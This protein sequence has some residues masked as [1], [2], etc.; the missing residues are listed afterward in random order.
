MPEPEIVI[1]DAL[2]EVLS[3]AEKV[4]VL[5]GA[6]VSADSGIPTFREA[7]TGLW[8]RFSPQELATPEAFHSNPK[9]VWEWYA[10]RRDL[11]SNSKPNAAHKALVDFEAFFPEFTLITQN[12]DGLHQMAG[13]KNVIE[14]H[15][16]I[17]KA[18]CIDEDRV[19][20]V[21]PVSNEYPLICPKCNGILRPEIVWFGESLP[22]IPLQK[23]FIASR[24]CAVFLSIGTS[25]IVE[26]AA[27]L[28]FEALNLGAVGIE[29]NLNQTGFSDYAHFS[30]RYKASDVLPII[31][32]IL[33]NH[34]SD[35]RSSSNRR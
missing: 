16:N 1:P 35:S 25:G 32:S 22:A 9:L 30:L 7:Q 5:T 6:G 14:L 15:G 28:P 17:T 11:I 3:K 21:W 2:I 26:P 10:W 24:N 34:H 33:K 23:A 29:V 27:S 19:L 20:E 4:T 18:R 12:V 8:E 31:V 13:N